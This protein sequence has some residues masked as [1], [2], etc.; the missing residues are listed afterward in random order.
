MS[1]SQQIK[2]TTTLNKKYKG[3]ISEKMIKLHSQHFPFVL[4]K[5]LEQQDK[6][7]FLTGFYALID[8]ANIDAKAH[9][10]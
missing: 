9:K 7:N 6:L 2:Q 5:H 4:D 8:Y 3:N 10:N 1:G